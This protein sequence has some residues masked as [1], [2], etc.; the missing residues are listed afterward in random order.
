MAFDDKNFIGQKIK[1]HR[2][3]LKLTQA[4]LA[5]KADLSEKHL[6]QIERGA[7]MPTLNTFFKLAKILEI[8]LTEF[9]LNIKEDKN[10][11]REKLIK[12]IYTFT[13]KELDFYT[14]LINATQKSIFKLKND[15]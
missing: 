11:I 8:N 14:D 10:K 7:F 5:E 13:D 3:K 15:K 1:L 6:G 12:T 9:G 2:K 4:Q